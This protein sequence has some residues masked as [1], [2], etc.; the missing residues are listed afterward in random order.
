M[1]SSAPGTNKTT[2]LKGHLGKM[3]E[4][5]A[6]LDYHKPDIVAIQETRIDDSISTS[7]LSPDSCP[8]NAYSSDLI[9]PGLVTNGTAKICCLGLILALFYS[10]MII[11]IYFG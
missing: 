9:I 5:L 3:L 6:F 11:K 7:E 10:T 2:S 1:A 4:L 8:Y